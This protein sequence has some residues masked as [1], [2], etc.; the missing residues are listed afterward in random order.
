MN[1]CRRG[2]EWTPANT[3]VRPDS[4]AECRA[5]KAILTNERRLLHRSSPKMTARR[6]DVLVYLA[7]AHPHGVQVTNLARALRTSRKCILRDLAA[8]GAYHKNGRAWL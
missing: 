7:I 5:C 8:V 1:T 6:E 4:K 3:Y 2:H